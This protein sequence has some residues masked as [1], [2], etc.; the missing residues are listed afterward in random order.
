MRAPRRPRPAPDVGHRVPATAH[1]RFE[2]SLR[3]A[4]TANA[5][6]WNE[7]HNLTIDLRAH[8]PV[9]K[10]ALAIAAATRAPDADATLYLFDAELSQLLAGRRS[11]GDL[12][13]TIEVRR[14]FTEDWCARRS[15]L[16]ARLGDADVTDT[17]L[18][19]V[20]GSSTA[21][22]PRPWRNVGVLHGM[23]T[24]AGTA[25]GPARVVRS[26]AD[27]TAVEP[28]EVLVCEATSPSWT[29]VFERLAACVCDTGGMLTHAAIISREQGVPCVCAVGSATSTIA[30]G[31]VLYVDGS[32]GVVALVAARPA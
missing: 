31:D 24:S 21:T 4:R 2:E 10:A 32:A 28:G 26:S 25:S 22:T 15:E 7:E 18:Q 14:E 30:T 1:N 29:P 27:L 17:V 11:W 19:G 8:L 5:I 23:G 6:W 12:A 9:R 16:P 13:E 20:V 3:R